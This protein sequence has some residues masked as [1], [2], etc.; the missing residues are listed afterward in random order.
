MANWLIGCWLIGA[1]LPGHYTGNYA[2]GSHTLAVAEWEVDPSAPHVLAFTDFTTGRFGVLT[3]A[4]PDTFALHEGIMAG[5]EAARLHFTRDAL[6]MGG[7]A[8]KRLP[9]RRV[10]LSAGTLFLPPGKGPFPAIVLVPA[11]RLGRT[12]MATFPNFFLS[13]GFAVLTYDRRPERAPFETYARDAIAATDVLRA[14]S[15][16]DGKR[17]GL[18][19]H[20]QGGWLSIVAAAL[21]PEKIAFVI[22]HSGMFV[23]AWQQELYRLGAESA[24]DGM[25]P[26]DVA[27]A[28][29]YEA[30]M[31][32]VARTGE[33]FDELAPIV[34]G[35]SWADLVYKPASLDDLRQVWRDDYSFDPRLYAAKV[36]CPV[37]ALFGGLDRSTP[38]ESAANL[39]AVRHLTVRFFPTADHA[40]LDAKTGGN[41]EIPA[42]TR[43]VPG[44]F[45]TM[46]EWLFGVRQR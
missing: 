31:M 44:M 40:F 7:Q 39:R 33:G 32:D 38:I 8:A 30:R 37:L 5:P 18:W 45:E 28:V 27:K 34:K 16:I 42:L 1:L 35:T 15:D 9:Q 43:F 6:V 46:R 24:A 20:S 23:P 4:G 12:S 21:A 13:A 11:G 36:Q 19:G 22:D 14:R 3:G 29:A 26:S 10:E 41:A 2:L 17:I 25:P